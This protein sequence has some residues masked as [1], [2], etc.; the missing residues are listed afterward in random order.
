MH[1]V[2]LLSV[3]AEDRVGELA[4]TTKVLADAGINVR[5]VA[6][7]PGEGFGV[8]KFLVDRGDE[9]FKRLKAEGF[10]VSLN[11]VLAV[12]VQDRPGGLH[13]VADV[14][15][16]HRLNVTNASG[17]VI[18]SRERAVLLIDVENVAQAQEALKA[19]HLHLLT[20]AELVKL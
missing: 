10:T 13:K 20:E 15:A 2:R 1:R 17:F 11:E 6:I 5:W 4:R 8:I 12:E 7:M 14:L 3:F 9:G 18:A 19:R 16:K